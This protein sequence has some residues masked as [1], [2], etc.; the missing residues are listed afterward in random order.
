MGSFVKNL[1]KLG[2]VWQ[3]ITLGGL[4]ANAL[5]TS[6]FAKSFKENGMLGY[7]SKV[8]RQERENDVDVLQHQ[9]WSGANYVDELMKMVTGGMSA[10]AAMGKGVTEDQFKK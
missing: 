10:T 2:F 1:G 9:K 7:V 4:H 8:Q 5:A 3:F 6:T